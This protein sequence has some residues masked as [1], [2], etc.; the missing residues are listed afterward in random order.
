MVAVSGVMIELSVVIVAVS[1]DAPKILL[2]KSDE[3]RTLRGLLADTLA[4][5]AGRSILPGIE[6]WSRAYEAGS[7]VKQACPS[8]MSSS[9]I[10]SATVSAILKNVPGDR[11]Q[12]PSVISPWCGIRMT[13]RRRR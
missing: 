13:N 11:G 6:P 7:T 2:V 9:S 4:C 5:L 12:S 10:P 1:D 3:L 8:V